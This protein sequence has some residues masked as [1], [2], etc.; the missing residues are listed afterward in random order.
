M[1]APIL[2]AACA[3]QLYSLGLLIAKAKP[4]SE[5][6][7]CV[8]FCFVDVR[9]IESKCSQPQTKPAMTRLLK[10]QGMPSRPRAVPSTLG[11]PTWISRARDYTHIRL[12]HPEPL[13]QAKW[14][15][16]HIHESPDYLWPAKT[17]QHT[18]YW[19]T[20]LSRW[21]EIVIPWEQTQNVWQNGDMGEY[22]PN[23]GIRKKKSPEKS[24]NK[25]KSF[26][27]LLNNSKKCSTNLRA[28]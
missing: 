4:S 25:T 20:T 13:L 15:T 8:L 18:V 24:P 16:R 21:G 28:E 5:I 6:W 17:I 19:E 27:C 14:H 2:E 12:H 7:V 26:I 10:T 3:L 9:G 22:A 23:E 1:V 11:R